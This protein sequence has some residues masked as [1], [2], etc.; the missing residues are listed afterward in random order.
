[1]LDVTKQYIYHLIIQELFVKTLNIKIQM[2]HIFT[3]ITI[4]YNFNLNINLILVKLFKLKFIKTKLINQV[5]FEEKKKNIFIF[6]KKD[7]FIF[8]IHPIKILTIF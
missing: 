6:I 5:L 2:K 1:M 8:I 4:I 7:L 3:S